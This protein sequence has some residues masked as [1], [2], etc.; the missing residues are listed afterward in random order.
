MYEDR[1]SE[2]LLEYISPTTNRAY[3]SNG[4]LEPLAILQAIKM[5][6][7]EKVFISV[8][9][10]RKQAFEDYRIIIPHDLI[11]EALAMS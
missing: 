11:N 4:R 10:F 3:D 8:S 2:F 6:F 1:L 5:L 7:E 9:D